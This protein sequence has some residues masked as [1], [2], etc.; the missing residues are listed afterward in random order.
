MCDS[1]L[2][3]CREKFSVPLSVLSKWLSYLLELGLLDFEKVTGSPEKELC[4]E[5]PV[6][7]CKS[8]TIMEFA[9]LFGAILL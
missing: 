4:S 2:F 1:E 3:N 9:M 7:L 6:S 5:I 8:T